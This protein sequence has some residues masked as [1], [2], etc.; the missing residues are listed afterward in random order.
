MMPLD[1]LDQAAAQF[2]T[3]INVNQLPFQPGK[4]VDLDPWETLV[5][6]TFCTNSFPDL[7]WWLG[8][9]KVNN[10]CCIKLDQDHPAGKIVG[11]LDLDPRGSFYFWDGGR[12]K[13]LVPDE[14]SVD[15]LRLK[16]PEIN[17]AYLVDD[18][19]Q[20]STLVAEAPDG[21]QRVLQWQDTFPTRKP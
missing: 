5:L 6:A 2:S 3:L 7:Q 4:L 1:D 17:L 18:V 13:K 8:T 20:T 15:L 10:C 12:T 11:Y 16:F 14:V 21:R 19:A 9:I